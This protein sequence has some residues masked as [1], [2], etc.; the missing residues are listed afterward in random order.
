METVMA[1]GIIRQT[2]ELIRSGE[3]VDSALQQTTKGASKTVKE[4]VIA[5]LQAATSTLRRAPAPDDIRQ[6]I[7]SA[8][9]QLDH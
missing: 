2:A 7:L 6:A 4:S 3:D 8:A 1:C 9:A 5:R